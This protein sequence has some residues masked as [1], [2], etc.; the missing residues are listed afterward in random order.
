[1]FESSP[2]TSPSY[3][4]PVTDRDRARALAVLLSGTES[5]L[6][7]SENAPIP[8]VARLDRILA[9][10]LSGRLDPALY[11]RIWRIRKLVTVV[12]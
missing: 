8:V 6:G 7:L 11:A 1:M 5:Q 12:H 2:P 4:R 10:A 9:G 3:P